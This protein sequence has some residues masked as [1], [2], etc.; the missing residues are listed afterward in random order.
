MLVLH[1]CH[2]STLLVKLGWLS[3]LCLFCLKTLGHRVSGQTVRLETSERVQ[4]H[5]AYPLS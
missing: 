1:V 5:T 2:P 3:W 4:R